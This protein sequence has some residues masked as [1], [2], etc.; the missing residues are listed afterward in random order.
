MTLECLQALP[1]FTMAVCGVITPFAP[2]EWAPV[3]LHPLPC[4][5]SR[6]LS[7]RDLN[8]RP[9]YSDVWGCGLV[10]THKHAGEAAETTRT[11]VSERCSSLTVL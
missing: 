3:P 7:C 4:P 5:A 11:D 8:S 1:S 2:P 9:T 10:L 6:R